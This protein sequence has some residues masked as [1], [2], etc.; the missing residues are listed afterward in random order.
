MEYLCIDFGTCNSVISYY[1]NDKINYIYNIDGNI[2]IPSTIFFITENIT[3]NLN[4]DDFIYDKHYVIGTSANNYLSSTKQHNNYFHQFKR[5]LGITNKS[6][7]DFINKFK[8]K[9]ELDDDTVYFFI[10]LDND[11]YIKINIIQLIQ[12]YFNGLKQFITNYNSKNNVLITCPAYFHDLQRMQLS[13]AIIG[14]KFNILKICNEPTVASLYYFDLFNIKTNDKYIIYDLGGGTMDVTVINYEPELDLCE[15]ID[16]YGD[17]EL[18]GIEITNIL[19]DN[20]YNKYNINKNS[21]KILSKIKNIAEDIKIKLT[22]SNNYVVILEEIL[23]NNDKIV[24]ELKI[25]YSQYE[26]NNIIQNVINKMIEPVILM[27]KKYNTKNIIFIGGTTQIP[28]L[29][30]KINALLNIDCKTI[31]CVDNN[32]FLYKSIVASGGTLLHKNLKNK[33]TL[34]LLDIIPMNI[35]I[36]SIN[37]DLIIM[38]PKNSKIPFSYE[39]IFSTSYD[40]QR[41]IDISIYEGLNNKCIN[42]SFIG[43]YSIMGIPPLSK[44][45]VLIKLIFQINENGILN[46]H[47][48]NVQNLGNE[49]NVDFKISNS[50]KLIPN[51][52]VKK[53]FGKLLSKKNEI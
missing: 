15:V 21:L 42:N 4:C 23:L 25:S 35:G 7:T 22:F 27:S 33:S 34:L 19:V 48:S 12:L 24:P 18:G 17:N 38:I 52:I 13:H 50:I 36:S 41:L 32:L 26:F 6:N 20:I 45:T 53:L 39:K 31:N 30:N 16:I 14:A 44:G 11:K 47:I 46:I 3:D 28:L 37:D 5:F 51:V 8:L 43:S 1:E 9:Y 2:L 29:Q 10:E 40:G 49:T